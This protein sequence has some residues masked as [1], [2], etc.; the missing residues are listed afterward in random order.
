MQTPRVLNLISL[1]NNAIFETQCND[2]L[3]FVQSNVSCIF[4]EKA[5][6]LRFTVTEMTFRPTS[7]SSL[8]VTGIIE[9]FD[10]S[11]N[12]LLVFHSN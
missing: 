4:F 2:F 3:L 7:H 11:Y 8:K 12:F 5:D 6:W 10:T 1:N 9:L